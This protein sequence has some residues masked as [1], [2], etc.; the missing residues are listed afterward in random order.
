MPKPGV[1]LELQGIYSILTANILTCSE[2]TNRDSLWYWE[3][4]AKAASC[5]YLLSI[6]NSAYFE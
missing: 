2:R 5:F 3:K 1:Y 6:D 4:T